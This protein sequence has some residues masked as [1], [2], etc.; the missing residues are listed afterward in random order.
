[1]EQ[2]RDLQALI[3]ALERRFGRRTFMAHFHRRVRFGS[4]RLSPV[5][6]GRRLSTP[7]EEYC[8][9]STAQY[10]SVRVTPTFGGGNA[11]R[12]TEQEQLAGHRRQEES[13]G[14]YA[15]DVEL[16]NQAGS[17]TS[18]RLALRVFQQGL[19]PEQLR[20]HVCL[21]RPE[22]LCEALRKAERVEV[23]LST[24]PSQP[25][26]ATSRP[27]VRQADCEE[28][29]DGAEEVCQAWVR[30]MFHTQG[31]SRGCTFTESAPPPAGSPEAWPSAL[32]GLNTRDSAMM[33]V[34]VVRTPDPLS[35]GC[36]ATVGVVALLRKGSWEDSDYRW[37]DLCALLGHLRH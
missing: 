31:G 37:L 34:G 21:T 24:R 23:D 7:T 18:P 33:G 14:A 36:V 20:Q 11:I 19:T 22:S 5:V 6:R 15:A 32:A 3:R 2:Q 16:Y 27:D 17:Q 25:P 29:L 28:V 26:S 1:M 13:L 35:G 9:T 10:G 30:S 8:E 12:V 4:V